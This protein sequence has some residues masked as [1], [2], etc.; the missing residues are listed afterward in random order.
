MVV[1]SELSPKRQANRKRKTKKIL[2]EAMQLVEEE[3]INGLTIHKLAKQLKVTVGALYR[4]F[5]SKD[6][7]VA[8]L[9]CDGMMALQ[10]SMEE[11]RKESEAW[12]ASD[13]VEASLYTL[14]VLFLLSDLYAAFAKTGSAHYRLMT[15]VL[16]HPEPM[17]DDQEA[18]RVL[19]VAQPIFAELAD[20]LEKAVEVGSLTS[21][22]ALD[23]ALVLWSS[24]YGVMQ[25]QKIGRL[26]PDLMHQ[27]RMLHELVCSLFIGWGASSSQVK[28][29]R[30]LANRF[31]ESFELDEL[32]TLNKYSEI[33]G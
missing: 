21:G 28:E 9:Q 4:Y 7:L 18:G 22:S 14:V 3:G 20:I 8:T 26:I 2:C 29:A 17:V 27:G 6:A 24:L 11:V 12:L 30:T 31:L 33:S 16:G 32:A 1:V 25:V 10:Q 23:R 15:M 13:E 19:M 5:P